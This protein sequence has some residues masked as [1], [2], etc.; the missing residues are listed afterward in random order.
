MILHCAGLGEHVD[1]IFAGTPVTAIPTLK[2]LLSAGHRILAVLT[3]PDAPVGRK[4]ILTPS[5]IASFAS[6]HGIS[7]IKANRIDDD[8][9]SKM[10]AL[11]ADLG[12]VVAFGA[13]L[14]SDVLSAPRFGW[15]N[16][17]FSA[18]PRWR[19]AAPVQWTLLSGEK[20]AATSVFRLVAEMDAGDTA[21]IVNH[22]L[23]GDE[24]C[25]E[26]LET[27]AQSGAKQVTDV[28]RDLNAGSAVF[29]PQS[30][31]VSFARKL[32][33]AD[34]ELK[35]ANS[36]LENFNRFRAVT[37]EPGA[38][39]SDAGVRIKVHVTQISSEKVQPGH[40]TFNA[41]TVLWGTATSA[42]QLIEIQP[43]GKQRMSAVDWARGRR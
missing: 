39:F 13:L 35:P 42:L 5:A 14:P 1:I 25:G 12:V 21:S 24:T 41:G 22:T 4:G 43:A 10:H 9:A 20:R 19:G 34:A 36:A 11:G 7:I 29:T 2:A 3:R 31:A 30:D 37:P 40:V 6:E 33:I 26:L 15:I 27:L 23:R 17:H 8:I 28:V 16:L 18:L 32:T 38:W